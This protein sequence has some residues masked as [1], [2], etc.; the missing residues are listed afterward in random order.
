MRVLLVST[1]FPLSYSDPAR[2]FIYTT[3]LM[4]LLKRCEVHVGCLLS[5][6]QLGM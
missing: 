1:Y 6:G 4:H 5:M 2:S 3:R